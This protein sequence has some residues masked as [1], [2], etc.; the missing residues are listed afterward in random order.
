MELELDV[1]VDL[2]RQ[3]LV[4]VGKLGVPADSIIGAVDRGAER[5]AQAGVAHEVIGGTLDR[6]GCRDRLGDALE[7]ELTLQRE[8]VAVG[9]EAVGAEGDLRVLLGVE[10]VRRAQVGVALRIARGE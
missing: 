3:R 2:V 6:A 5:E 10:E 8:R 4:A 9:G 1:Q 7:R